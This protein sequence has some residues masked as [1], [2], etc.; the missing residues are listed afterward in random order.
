MMG[1]DCERITAAID[2]VKNAL[3]AGLN[4]LSNTA[5]YR[6][7]TTGEHGE[8]EN[9]HSA[10]GFMTNAVGAM[11]G[12]TPDIVKMDNLAAGHFT[13]VNSWNNSVGSPWS[14]LDALGQAVTAA[15]AADS[16]TYLGHY[17][18][19]MGLMHIA[20]ER[21]IDAKYAMIQYNDYVQRGYDN[22]YNGNRPSITTATQLGEATTG[23]ITHDYSE[24]VHIP[25]PSYDPW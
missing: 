24:N 10:S 23:N 5:A 25:K 11:A 18:K 9:A 12:L 19:L 13:S 3:I 1:P 16:V 17:V 2:A 7:T 6:I 4:S 21:A 15:A 8:S 20:V 22:V 14:E